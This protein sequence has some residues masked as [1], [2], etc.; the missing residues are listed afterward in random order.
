MRRSNDG[1]VYYLIQ[2]AVI[3]ALFIEKNQNNRIK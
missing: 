1:D 2:V 3:P